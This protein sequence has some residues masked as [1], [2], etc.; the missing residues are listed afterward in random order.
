M[1]EAM[2]QAVGRVLAALEA[3]GVADNTIVIFTSDNGGLSTSEGSPTTNLPYRAGKGWLYEGGIREPFIVRWPRVTPE[4]AATSWPVTSTDIYPT[5]LEAAALPLLPEQHSD[6]VSFLAAMKDP[7][8]T[9]PERVLFWH[10]P[11]WGNQGGT[12]GAAVRRG[13][14]KL[15]QWFWGKPPELFH[16]GK[17]PGEQENVAG[18]NPEVL[19]ELQKLLAGMQA[20]TKALMPHPNPHPEEPFDRW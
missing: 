16:L 15:I 5:I 10:Y 7:A 2:D 17:D 14:W 6:G 9:D 8:K 20:A 19:A 1:V 11:H 13:D 12:P 4:G 3:S 18:K